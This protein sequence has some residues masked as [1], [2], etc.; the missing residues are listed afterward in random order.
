MA[1]R[2]GS[3][4]LTGLTAGGPPSTRADAPR[5]TAWS[6]QLWQRSSA[7]RERF[8]PGTLHAGPE[9]IVNHLRPAGETDEQACPALSATPNRSSLE[10]PAHLELA[11]VRGLR[12]RPAGGASDYPCQRWASSGCLNCRR[13]DRRPGRATE[14]RF[15]QCWRSADAAYGFAQLEKTHGNGLTTRR[16]GSKCRSSSNSVEIPLMS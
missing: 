7:V 13:M 5:R 16:R 11:L 12:L 8:R 3:P 4:R 9:F 6:H 1:G 14:D 15:Q 10:H 2:Q